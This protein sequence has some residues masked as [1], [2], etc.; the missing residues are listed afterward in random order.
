SQTPAKT[1]SG[2]CWT[3]APSGADGARD[4]ARV[5]RCALVQVGSDLPMDRP[6]DDI[7]AALNDKC[8]GLI[9]AAAARG[10]RM[11]ALPELFNTPYFATVTDPRWYAA[12]E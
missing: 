8:A 7:K 9:A 2:V 5:I 6:V 10:A 4:M 12:A 1:R 3:R 11:L